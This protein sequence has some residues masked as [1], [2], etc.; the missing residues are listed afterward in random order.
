VSEETRYRSSGPAIVSET[1]DDETI[2]V[3]LDTGS[4]Y[5]LN[6]VGACIWEQVERGQTPGEA[7][8]QVVARFGAGA[9][10]ARRAMDDL[11]SEL[12]EEGL[13]AEIPAGLD[14]TL[15]PNGAASGGQSAGLAYVPPVMNKH[16][17][18]QELLLLDPIHEVDE[19]GWPSRL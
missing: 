16:S 14:V 12:V 6:H 13:I 9:D 10:E 5:D 2:I 3:N 1:V 8:A 17:D 15:S 18:M 7:A 11:V 4:Y 19:A